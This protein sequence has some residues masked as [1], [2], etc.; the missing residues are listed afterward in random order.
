M[1]LTSLYKLNPLIAKPSQH[2]IENDRDQ[3]GAESQFVYTLGPRMIIL[4]VFICNPQ[5]RI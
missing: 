4:I 5:N 2:A 3:Q 1:P